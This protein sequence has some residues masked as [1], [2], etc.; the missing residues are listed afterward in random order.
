MLEDYS[1]AA[2]R[3]TQSERH[4]HQMFVRRIAQF[5]TI[6]DWSAVIAYD[7]EFRR[8]VHAGRLPLRWRDEAI[9]LVVS[10]LFASLTTPSGGR[11]PMAWR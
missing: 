5:A 7:D 4:G 6:Y 1:L 2:G 9:G 3:I 10:I 8:M 11:R